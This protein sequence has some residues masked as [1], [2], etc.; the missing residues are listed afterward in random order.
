MMR[1]SCG[2]NHWYNP[3][4]VFEMA[5]STASKI[6][7]L[8]DEYNASTVVVHGNSGVSMGMA[9]MMYAAQHFPKYLQ[10]D[11]ALVRKDNDNSHGDAIEGTGY[12]KDFIILDDFV[13]SGN[14]VRRIMNKIELL[15]K[16]RQCEMPRC[17]GVL[18]YATD[19]C[20]TVQL[21]QGGHLPIWSS[22]VHE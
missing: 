6:V 5:S 1:I 3:E 14:T 11:L 20:G 13:A 8:L 9:A 18:V 22:Y 17:K 15:C 16:Q 4:R 19:T 2:Y 10:F 21:D 7:D 12:L